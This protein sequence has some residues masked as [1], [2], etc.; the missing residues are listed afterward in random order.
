MSWQDFINGVYEM[1]GA[2]FIVLSI[3]NLYKE[4]VVKGVDWRAVAFFSTWSVWNLYYYP[5]LDQWAS[6]FGGIFIAI[7]NAVWL[8]MMIY[9]IRKEKRELTE[10]N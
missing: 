5:H 8:V 1:L 10:L 7:A 3:L 9:Y 4:K 2:P 6:F